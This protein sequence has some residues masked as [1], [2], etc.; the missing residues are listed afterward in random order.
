MQGKTKF[1]F[2]LF[3]LAVSVSFV[4]A[5]ISLD[6][7]LDKESYSAGEEVRF[8]VLLLEDNLPKSEELVVYFSDV[9]DKK[10]MQETVMTNVENTLLIEDDFPSGFWKIETQYQNKSVRR[11]FSVKEYQDIKFSIYDDRLI[12]ENKGNVVYTKTIQIM[13]G[14]KVIPQKLNLRVGG[15]KEIKLVAPDGNYNIKVTDGENTLTR[16]N[17]HLTGTGKVIGAID[18]NLA[19]GSML[20]GARDPDEEDK[21]FSSDKM[22]VAF[23]FV[24]AIFGLGILLLI[25]KRLR[26]KSDK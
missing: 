12:I 5:Q 24:G 26:K 25:E 13:I 11:D 20:G 2:V 8:N 3:I 6:I 19:D 15:V 10:Q 16:L 14:D 21:F 1:L 9:F 22:P 23:I 4:S 18:Q 17:V 7:R